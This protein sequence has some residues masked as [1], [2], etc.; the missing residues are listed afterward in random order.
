MKDTKQ[1]N[2]NMDLKEHNIFLL[3]TQVSEVTTN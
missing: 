3:F 2:K 1:E